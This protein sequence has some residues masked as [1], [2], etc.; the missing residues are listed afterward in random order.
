MKEKLIPLAQHADYAAAAEKLA[1]YRAQLVAAKAEAESIGLQVRLIQQRTP[2]T[3]EQILA[4]ADG[5]MAGTMPADLP[6]RQRRNEA[7]IAA[8]R[9]AIGVQETELARIRNVHS[10]AAGKA[11]RARHIATV[12]PLLAAMRALADALEAERAVRDELDELGYSATQ[13]PGMGFV[14][15]AWDY[16][17]NPRDTDSTFWRYWWDERERYVAT[18]VTPAEHDAALAQADAAARRAADAA[19]L[20]TAPKRTSPDRG[21]LVR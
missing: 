7:L 11:T 18:G 2:E 4:A 13:L 10:I 21:E 8:L 5:A 12:G 16:Q 15:P 9:K 1:G 6:E 20:V 17:F 14:V 19:K 3:P